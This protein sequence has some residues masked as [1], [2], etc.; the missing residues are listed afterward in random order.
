MM[1]TTYVVVLGAM[2]MWAGYSCA[3]NSNEDRLVVHPHLQQPLQREQR[4]NVLAVTPAPV[5]VEA[6]SAASHPGVS[7]TYSKPL[8]LLEFSANQ[9][10]PNPKDEIVIGR[11]SFGGAPS[12]V[13]SEGP[14]VL[15]KKLEANYTDGFGQNVSASILQ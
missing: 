5:A 14:W 3:C 13:D 11:P 7:E 10:A 4:L 15:F 8:L 1:K 12:K 2:L 6:H 9:A